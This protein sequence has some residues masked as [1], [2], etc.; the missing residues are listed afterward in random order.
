MSL[1]QK[2]GN[3]VNIFI[4]NSACDL[5]NHQNND[6]KPYYIVSIVIFSSTFSC[7]AN[8]TDTFSETAT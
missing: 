5:N 7:F 6:S 4:V 1:K 8:T 3:N 2:E